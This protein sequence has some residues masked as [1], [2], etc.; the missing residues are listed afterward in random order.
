MKDAQ[1]GPVTIPKE[2]RGPL[3]VSAGADVECGDDA[4]VG[5]KVRSSPRADVSLRNA[6]GVAVT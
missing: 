1:Q 4:I 2:A 6:F 3:D 5:G